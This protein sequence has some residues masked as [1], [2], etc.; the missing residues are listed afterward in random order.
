MHPPSANGS[1]GKTA[2]KA[3]VVKRMTA[4]KCLR[5]GRKMDWV[6]DWRDGQMWSLEWQVKEGTEGDPTRPRWTF[7]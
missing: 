7:K 1:P 2:R 4:S 3:R 5:C 6:T